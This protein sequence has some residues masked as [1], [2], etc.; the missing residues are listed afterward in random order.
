MVSRRLLTNDSRSFLA[1]SPGKPDVRFAPNGPPM[2]VFVLVCPAMSV[3]NLWIVVHLL[4]T[5]RSPCVHL[6]FTLVVHHK[7]CKRVHPEGRVGTPLSLLPLS[8]LLVSLVKVRGALAMRE[9]GAWME[10][11][12]I[13]PRAMPSVT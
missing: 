5:F 6:L 9:F 2:S 1:V 7:D 10:Q 8:P 3:D 13:P 4:F 12:G 11:R